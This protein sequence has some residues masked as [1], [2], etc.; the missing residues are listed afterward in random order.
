VEKTKKSKAVD[1]PS[2]RV[3]LEIVRGLLSRAKRHPEELLGSRQEFEDFLA[4][5]ADWEFDEE[6]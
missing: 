1:K 3:R 5:I 4:K 6:K 2:A